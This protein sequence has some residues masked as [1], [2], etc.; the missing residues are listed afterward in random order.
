MRHPRGAAPRHPP[1]CAL[2]LHHLP[3]RESGEARREPRLQQGRNRT[4]LS[5]QSRQEGE[6]QRGSHARPARFPAAAGPPRTAVEAGVYQ[7]IRLSPAEAP[8]PAGEGSCAQHAEL[9]SAG[10]RCPK[11]PMGNL[12]V[13]SDGAAGPLTRALDL[14]QRKTDPT[15]RGFRGFPPLFRFRFRGKGPDA[16]HAGSLLLLERQV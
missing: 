5:S 13:K 4:H 8:S 1:A 6:W 3:P 14:V 2:R 10:G 7:K 12:V 15:N 11:R 16:E 9:P